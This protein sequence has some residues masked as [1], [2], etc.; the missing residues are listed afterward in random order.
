MAMTWVNWA[1]S[2]GCRFLSF[3]TAD[4][5]QAP[6]SGVYVIV[7]I[8]AAPCTV[9]VGHGDV[10]RLVA[11]DRDDPEVLKFRQSGELEITWADAPPE[12]AAGYARHLSDWAVLNP[13]IKLS[14]LHA[15]PIPVN[16]PGSPVSA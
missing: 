13:C 2:G 11:I 8:G 3:E 16:V 7:L 1:T 15:Q 9:K 14:D 6:S 5:G 4:L 12:L 10:P